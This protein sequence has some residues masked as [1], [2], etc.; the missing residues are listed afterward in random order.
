MSDK[1]A[2]RR[3][4]AYLKP[5]YANLT[6]SLANTTGKSVSSIVSDAVKEKFDKMPAHEKERILSREK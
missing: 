5:M 4:L 1:I 2:D 3:V 6:K